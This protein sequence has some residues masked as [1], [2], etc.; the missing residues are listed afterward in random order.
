MVQCVKPTTQQRKVSSTSILELF[1][2]VDDFCLG[3]TE[4]KVWR[5]LGTGGAKR[6]PKPTL[7]LSE[8]M[9]I[10]I[11][12]HQSHYRDFKAY[13]TQHVMVHLRSEFPKPTFRTLRIE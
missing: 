10:I 12:F 9:T 13:Y 8:M 1:C 3:L 5:Q 2:D 4:H 7:A 6:G 11:H